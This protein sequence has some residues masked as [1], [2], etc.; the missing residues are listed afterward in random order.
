MDKF[1]QLTFT[2]WWSI[3][4]TIIGII[5]LIVSV[6]LLVANKKERER[7]TAQ[8]KIWQHHAN[9]ISLGLKRIVQDAN[10]NFYSNLKDVT[11]A[12]W[13]VETSAFSLYQSLYE[14][15]TITE[16]EYKQEQKEMREEL[17]NKN[18]SNLKNSK[19]EIV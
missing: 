10:T 9:G 8:V 1:N 16:D 3:I 7:R 15:R 2:E 4:S 11:S 13:A 5:L 14:E 19:T 18:Q 17:K 6:W 12:V